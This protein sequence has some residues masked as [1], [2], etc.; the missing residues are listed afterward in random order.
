MCIGTT[1][2]P[3]NIIFKSNNITKKL[4]P[5]ANILSYG[6]KGDRDDQMAVKT[7]SKKV[8]NQWG[9]TYYKATNHVAVH[10]RLRDVKKEFI[11]ADV[12]FVDMSEKKDSLG[13]HRSGLN[14]LV[15]I[16]SYHDKHE[17][18]Q[19]N[20]NWT[21]VKTNPQSLPDD[22]GYLIAYG[23]QGEGNPMTHREFLEIGDISEAIRQ[24]LMNRV[25]P[26]KRGELDAKSLALVA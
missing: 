8:T 5:E 3:D 24:F 7:G 21:R 14:V 17:W 11:S 2:R 12:D 18:Q 13:G 16:N 6:T 26:L 19:V 20:G 23:G 15:Y 9:H 1:F 10:V 25:L 22:E 4:L